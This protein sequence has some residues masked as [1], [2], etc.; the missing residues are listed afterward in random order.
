MS[1]TNPLTSSWDVLIPQSTP[2]LEPSHDSL[3]GDRDVESYL[4]EFGLLQQPGQ[5]HQ[6]KMA[7]RFGPANHIDFNLPDASIQTWSLDGNAR[8]PDADFG[9]TSPDTT[10]EEHWPLYHAS[11]FPGAEQHLSTTFFSRLGKFDTALHCDALAGESGC[12]P[13][14]LLHQQEEPFVTDFTDPIMHAYELEAAFQD[15]RKSWPLSLEQEQPPYAQTYGPIIPTHDGTGNGEERGASYSPLQR[16]EFPGC[17]EPSG[18]DAITSPV[19][20]ISS[21]LTPSQLFK[22]QDNQYHDGSSK[23]QS[24]NIPDKV[25][26]LFPGHN[27]HIFLNDRS[28]GEISHRYTQR[29]NCSPKEDQLQFFKIVQI[30]PERDATGDFSDNPTLLADPSIDT[31][32]PGFPSTGVPCKASHSKIVTVARKRKSPSVGSADE[33]PVKTMAIQIVQE[34][35]LGGSLEPSASI[36]TVPRARR[37]GP[38][39]F[40]GRREAAMRRKDKSVC[41]WCRLAKKKCSGESPCATCLEQ[42]KSIFFEQP[43][44]KA[45]FFQIVESGTCNYISQRAIN[46]PTPDGSTRVRM[47]LPATFEMKNL[48][49]LLDKRRGKFNIRARQSWGTL[50][51][52][53]LNE[54][55]NY[56]KDLNKSEYSPR[57]DLREFIDRKILKFN[58]WTNCVR[59]C[60]PI[61]NLFSLLSQW[62]NMPSRASYDFVAISAD[63]PNRPMNVHNPEDSV[64]ILLAAQLSRIICRKL[65]VDGFRALQN[66]LNKNK[67]DSIPYDA[68]TEFVAQLGQILLTLR[69]RVSWWELL[70]DGGTTPDANKER[71]E[72]RVRRLCQVLY[73]YYT[74]VKLKLPAWTTPTGLDGIWSTYAD[75]TR[76]WDD[77]PSAASIDGFNA[78]MARG[79]ELIQ[80]AGVQSRISKFCK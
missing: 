3:Q 22:Q 69:W 44:V 58:K 68:F 29:R 34:D 46:H 32:V 6:H 39:S 79:K 24:L 77:F 25:D 42:A 27:T 20:D 41:V 19:L 62:N 17:G 33:K 2:E 71:Y 67:W 73:F 65:E 57:Y 12:L 78:W 4:E 10:G 72:D 16:I 54:T 28:Q 52:I 74:S 60:D 70:G 48:L 43:C 30:T 40:D 55:Y 50:Y 14:D 75:A 38:L 49:E 9:P 47:E 80:E 64:D 8:S 18:T 35:G 45:D 5:T 37:N 15:L 13:P 36:P 31:T 59:E 11:L 1:D 7:G 56:L 66:A 61:N 21:K 63:Q 53:D 26:T 23:K 76:I 51:V